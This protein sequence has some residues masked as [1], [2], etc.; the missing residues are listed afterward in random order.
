MKLLK[1]SEE[2]SRGGSLTL[3]FFIFI[4][5]LFFLFVSGK[6]IASKRSGCSSFSSQ[7]LSKTVDSCT[8]EMCM[9][10]KMTANGM[11]GVN[12]WH[13]DFG[14]GNKFD[15]LTNVSGTAVITLDVCNMYVISGTFVITVAI[16]PAHSIC[17]SQYSVVIPP[18][19]GSSFTSNNLCFGSPTQ[20]TSQ[21]F[22]G[23]T[24]WNWDFGDGTTS[25]QL[26]PSH[27]YT[28]PGTYT[29]TLS[30]NAGCNQTIR[31]IVQVYP[32][33]APGYTTAISCFGNTTCFTDLSAITGGTLVAWNWNF[34][35]VNSG[36]ANVSNQKNPCHTFTSPGNFN[37]TFTVTTGTGCKNAITSTLTISPPPLSAFTVTNACLNMPNMFTDASFSSSTDP[38]NNWN[39]NFGEGNISVQQDP[40]HFYAAAGTYT[41]TLIVTTAR[42]CKDTV[43]KSTV[44]YPL[45]AAGFTLIAVC[46]KNPPCFSDLSLVSSGSIVMWSWNFGDPASGAANISAAKN[47]GHTFTAP[48]NFNVT[49]TVTSDQGCIGTTGLPVLINPSPVSDFTITNAC[50]SFPNL[51]M[52]SSTS[53]FADTIT[54][55]DWNLGDGS[56]SVQQVFSH[57]YSENQ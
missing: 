45:P 52:N 54:N 20:F 6:I 21:L 48:G 12:N 7:I 40:S 26:N 31:K 23:V 34:G 50:L 28:T 14:D 39:W 13:I 29:V 3:P 42:G 44:V 30:V 18:I 8:G 35:D 2:D 57:I 25:P 36:A 19:N 47:P 38:I 46:F 22:S 11:H 16:T 10:V 32:P 15:T 37:V 33:P 49:F 27:A 51:F 1:I 9:K 17:Q 53:V 41:V 4:A 56:S 24:L 43:K 55:W 5:L